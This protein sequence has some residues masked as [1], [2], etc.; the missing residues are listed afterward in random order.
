MCRFSLFS[1]LSSSRLTTDSDPIRLHAVEKSCKVRGKGN[2]RTP[3]MPRQQPLACPTQSEGQETGNKVTIPLSLCVCVSTKEA[4]LKLVDWGDTDSS[5]LQ[6]RSPLT[7]TYPKILF[8][9]NSSL[10]RVISLLLY[11]AH[12]F[13]AG[14]KAGKINKW[15]YGKWSP[16]IK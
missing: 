8:K 2:P 9:S 11:A 3:A 4:Q 15:I 12:D 13:F 14:S 5:I 10:R 6:Q 16:Y 1:C 7:Q